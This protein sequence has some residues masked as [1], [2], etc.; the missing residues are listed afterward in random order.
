MDWSEYFL[1]VADQL[2]LNAS[3]THACVGLADYFERRSTGSATESSRL[4]LY[5]TPVGWPAAA[6]APGADLRTTLKAMARFG[7]PPERHWPFDPEKI[8]IEPEPFLYSYA[9]DLQSLLYVRLDPDPMPAGDAVLSAVKGHLAAGLPSAFGFSAFDTLSLDPDILPPTRFDSVR[10]G[11]AVVAVGFDDTRRV[12]ST[13]GA[14]R[15]RAPWGEAWGES[16]YG[17]LPYAY[18][19]EQLAVD[20]WTMLRPRVAGLGRVSPASRINERSI[21]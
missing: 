1:P 7:L 16:G 11:G 19:L 4:F 2:G 14:L 3:S 18:V 20:F 21:K 15:V 12:R 13:K 10:G 5:Q 8:D 6:G 9:R 17:W